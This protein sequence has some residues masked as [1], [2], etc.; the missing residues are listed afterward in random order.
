MTLWKDSGGDLSARLVES[1][2]LV[3]MLASAL[4]MMTEKERYFV[5]SMDQATAVSPKQLFWLRDLNE[6]YL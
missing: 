1:Q 4:D 6:K 3:D 5:I 2:R